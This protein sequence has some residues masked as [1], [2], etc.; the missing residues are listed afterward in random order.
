MG[1]IRYCKITYYAVVFQELAALIVNLFH[2]ETFA[3]SAVLIFKLLPSS[4]KA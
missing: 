2:D 1:L 4:L 3:Q